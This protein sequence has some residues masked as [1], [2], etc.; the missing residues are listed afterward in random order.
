MFLIFRDVPA[1]YPPEFRLDPDEYRHARARRLRAGDAVFVGDGRRRRRR[2]EVADVPDAPAVI[3]GTPTNASEDG[4]ASAEEQYDEPDIILY[5]AVPEGKRLDWLLQKTVEVGV[6]EIRPIVTE[7]S[8]Q[9][10][11]SR[12]RAERIVLE[13]AVQSRRFR[14]P[15]VANAGTLTDVLAGGPGDQ[16]WFALDPRGERSLSEFLQSAAP[17]PAAAFFVG[18]EGGFSEGEV[19]TLRDGGVELLTCG[20]TILRVETAA[21]MAVAAAGI[22]KY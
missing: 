22:L 9:R 2:Y 20:Q 11:F 19:A 8:Q 3:V 17:G 1:D 18:P 7:H 4:A 6:T 12:E 10:S 21:V 14:L 16:A 15:S 13:A 5:T